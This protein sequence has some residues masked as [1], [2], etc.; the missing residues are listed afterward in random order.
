MPSLENYLKGCTAVFVAADRRVLVG[1]DL[2]ECLEIL[3]DTAGRRQRSLQ[4]L[5]ASCRESCTL[6]RAEQAALREGCTDRLR[7]KNRA[8][9]RRPMHL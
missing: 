5:V 1:S 6:T 3:R 2:H 9:A 7:P 4:R 8:A